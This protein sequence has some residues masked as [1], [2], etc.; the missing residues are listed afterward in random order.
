[1]NVPEQILSAIFLSGNE[2]VLIF[3]VIS[4][5][6]IT[7]NSLKRFSDLKNMDATKFYI[8]RFARIAPCLLG[9]LVILTALHYLGIKGYVISS[10]FS[11]SE[12]LFSALTFHVNWLEGQKGY[13]PA[14]WDILWSLSV[15]EV[16]YFAFPL[17][18]LISRR[19]S[20]LYI[21]LLVL[22]L[23]GPLNRF[24]LEGNKIWQSKAYLSC[25]D[26][27]AVGCLFALLSHK[28][29]LSE[30]ATN[31][32]SIIGILMVVF[33]L[34]VKRDP[35][36]S[37][38]GELYLFKTILSLGVGLLLISSVRQQLKPVF[39][40]LLSPLALYGRLS[41]EIYLTHIFVVFSGVKLYKNYDVGLNDS[42]AWLVGIIF[43]CGFLGYLIERF[44]SKPMN[45]WIRKKY[46]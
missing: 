7:M 28:R 36:F 43:M 30:L 8:F 25:M 45:L 5:F 6:L 2:G 40:K 44:F 15:E 12:T 3:F 10:K 27:I 11:Y 20:T 35:D 24:A 32:F 38:L 18:C 17:I 34:L 23:I 21:V 9:L 16:F 26:S 19:K 46:A 14:S 39:Q 13:L 22:I 4:G 1:V 41:Y 42:F 31:L 37:A 29:T 33:I